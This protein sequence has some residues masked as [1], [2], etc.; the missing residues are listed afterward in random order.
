MV[1]ACAPRRMHCS[2]HARASTRFF[3]MLR[4]CTVSCK[5]CKI[6]I[7]SRIAQAV[8]IPIQSDLNGVHGPPGTVG[9]VVH[10]RLQRLL[11]VFGEAVITDIIGAGDHLIG[12]GG[13][14]NERIQ[15]VSLI[16]YTLVPDSFKY[17]IDQSIVGIMK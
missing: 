15:L 16:V 9:G 12:G 6:P 17:Q 5:T 14:A 13:L 11:A 7:G 3:K 8:L 2:W 1:T 10:E 4:Q